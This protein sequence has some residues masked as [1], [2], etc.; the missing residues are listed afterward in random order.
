MAANAKTMGIV[1]VAIIVIAA[2]LGA[3][4]IMSVP[5]SANGTVSIYVKDDPAMW[6]HINVTFSEV[7]VHSSDDN[8]SW[9][10]LSIKNGTLD[11]IALSNVSALL[12]SG[13]IPAGNYTQIRLVVI[14]VTGMM[15]NG[16]SVTFTVPSGELKTTHPFN[17]TA[18]AT[19]RLT[20]EFDLDRSIVQTGNGEWKFTP[21]LGAVRES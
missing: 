18:G 20:L 12:A 3:A 11:L 14:S 17:V 6:S 13:E 15:T 7:K 10:T 5:A 19:N 9:M 2:A 1:V 21:V 4:A 16:T 8:G